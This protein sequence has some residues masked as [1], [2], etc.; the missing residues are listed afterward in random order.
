MAE[1]AD[2]LISRLGLAKSRTHAVSLIKDGLVYADGKPVSKPSQLLE[3]NSVVT[4]AEGGCPYVS[5]GGLKLQAALLHFG[6]DVTGL[7]AVDIGASTGGF[8]HCLLNAGAKRVY[9]VDVGIGQL[10]ESLKNDSRVISLEK[11][12]ARNLDKSLFSDEIHIAVMDV[13]FISQT[14]IYPSVSSLLA[15]GGRLITLIKPQ[16]ELGRQAL[17]RHGVVRDA[18]KRFPALKESLRQAAASAGL[19]M[20]DTMKSPISGGDGNIEYLALFVK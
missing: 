19:T 7:T 6:I 2:V 5:R 10:A 13:S 9:A 1:R 4:V 11:I 16:F 14:L 17:N 3:E 15:P 20:T 8:T 12:N 18:E